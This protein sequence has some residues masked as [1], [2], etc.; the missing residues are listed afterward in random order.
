MPQCAPLNIAYARKY[1]LLN[2]MRCLH[3][4]LIGGLIQVQ[5]FQCITYHR[6]IHNRSLCA[7]P[8]DEDKSTK[9]MNTDKEKY[10]SELDDLTPPSVNFSRNSML[11]GDDP[12][13]QRKNTPL[14]VWRGVKSFFPSFVTGAW[15]DSQ[16]DK[17][18]VEHL[19]NTAFVRL[20]TVLMACVYI[21]NLLYGHGLVMNVGDGNF[22]LP[23]LIVFS[24]ILVILR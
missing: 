15:E 14:K 5:A 24:I 6:Q 22:E 23:P 10:D 12:P 8:S 20:P 4:L 16:G 17:K 1:T 9:M 19:Y 21:R 13:S 2:N 3:L 7:S 11:F 18:P